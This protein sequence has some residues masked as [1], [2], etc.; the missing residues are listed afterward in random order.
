MVDFIATC[1]DSFAC[2]SGLQDFESFEKSFGGL[3]A[4][5]L[6]V[7]QRVIARSG[8]C[9]FSIWLQVKH[10]VNEWALGKTPFV[11][12]SIT[13]AARTVWFKPGK[14]PPAGT[15][16]TIKH[17]N[18]EDYAPYHDHT[19]KHFRRP[20]PVE[21][22]NIMQSETLHNLD[23]FS[24]Q[25]VKAT[26][27]QFDR[28]EPNARIELLRKWVA[29]FFNFEIK[30]EYDN[31]ILLQ[32]HMLLKKNNI[33]HVF[34]GWQPDLQNLMD[35]VNYV[36]VDWGHWSKYHPD[37]KGTGHCD[38]VGHAEVFKLIKPSIEAQI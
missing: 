35:E 37:P 6:G 30:Q 9:N 29:D 1:G 17:L 2:G 21:T 24:D 11:I 8:C 23:S 12:V 34:M 38:K 32:A 36:P 26:W 15:Q 10:V 28:H 4:E 19:P 18:Y 5:Y 22:N 25:K 13:N 7:E 20:I 33:P 3:A 16:P 14:E 31:G 27:V